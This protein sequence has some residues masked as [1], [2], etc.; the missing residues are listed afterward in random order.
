MN[1]ACETSLFSDPI[2]VIGGHAAAA[3][4]QGA[5][6]LAAHTVCFHIIGNLETMY[7]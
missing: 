7:D 6:L 4:A 2:P 5:S 1:L 3:V